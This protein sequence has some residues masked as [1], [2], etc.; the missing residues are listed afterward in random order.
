METQRR[1]MTRTRTALQVVEMK[2]LYNQI[3]Q[4]L[5]SLE[6]SKPGV[7]TLHGILP[8]FFRQYSFNNVVKSSHVVSVTITQFCHY[9]AKLLQTLG[10]WM[11]GAGLGH[12]LQF[13]NLLIH[14]LACSFHFYFQFHLWGQG[15]EKVFTEPNLQTSSISRHYCRHIML[16]VSL[17]LRAYFLLYNLALYP[18][19]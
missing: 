7:D 15:Q 10:K 3:F 1:Q 11:G 6:I 8:Q 16:Q 14:T 2:L 18:I 5:F 12:E 17:P 4:M 13:G 9:S 19:N